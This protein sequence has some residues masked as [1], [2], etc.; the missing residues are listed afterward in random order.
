MK[1]NILYPNENT[2]NPATCSSTNQGP[3]SFLSNKFSDLIQF[4]VLK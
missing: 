2:T 1:I 3:Q 4:N